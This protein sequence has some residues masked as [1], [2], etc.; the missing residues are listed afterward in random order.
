M[1]VGSRRRLPGACDPKVVVDVVRGSAAR[2]GFLRRNGDDR[3]GARARGRASSP[4]MQIRIS[5]LFLAAA[6]VAGAPSVVACQGGGSSATSKYPGTEEGAKQLLGEFLKP[7]ADHPALTKQ[8][9]PSK[10]D[11]KAVYG[12][13]ADKLAATY[14]PV[15]DK[16]DLVIKPNEGQ[17]ELKL[18]SASSDDLKNGTGNAGEF[19]GGYKKVADK[20]QSGVTLYRFKF[21]KPGEDSGMA[22][23]GLV[24]VNGHWV[25]IPKPWRALGG[26]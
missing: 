13:A 23:D 24:Y 12:D 16:G 14:D 9:R 2:I 1:I 5:K 20:L 10:D 11:Y 18:A 4:A 19:P 6:L 3:G 7:G 26:E 22:F 25:I 17:T 8:L 21:V 15:W